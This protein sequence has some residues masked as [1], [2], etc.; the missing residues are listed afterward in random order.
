M[1]VLVCA[2]KVNAMQ[3]NANNNTS[4][5]RNFCKKKDILILFFLI[6]K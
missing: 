3:L 1:V 5:V 6:S 2:L 4:F